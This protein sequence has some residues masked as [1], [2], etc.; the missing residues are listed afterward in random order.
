MHH[1]PVL[2]ERGQEGGL[3]IDAQRLH[4]QPAAAQMGQ[5]QFVVQRRVL[6]VQDAQRMVEDGGHHA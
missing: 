1:V 5:H 4:L 3:G 6:Q 2:L